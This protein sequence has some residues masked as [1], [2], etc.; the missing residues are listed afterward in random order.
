MF[1]LTKRS[2]AGVTVLTG[3]VL[4]SLSW[5]F[6][7]SF[8]S[9]LHADYWENFTFKR[10]QNPNMQR[11]YTIEIAF[12]NAFH[13]NLDPL[14]TANFLLL[15]KSVRFKHPFTS[16]G[17]WPKRSDIFLK[18]FFLPIFSDNYNFILC[19]SLPKI[20]V[21]ARYL[22]NYCILLS[23][24]LLIT[25]YLFP[26]DLRSPK[27]LLN[28]TVV[29]DQ[30]TFVC[31]HSKPPMLCQQCLLPL[32]LWYILCDDVAGMWVLTFWHPC[33]SV[34]T[35]WHLCHSVVHVQIAWGEQ[36]SSGF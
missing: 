10:P 21:W 17:I 34:L 9:L 18:V 3:I 30:Y 32:C 5:R 14:K 24:I 27:H 7:C 15:S 23:V 33:H 20:C 11:W 28:N 6:I 4:L 16:W 12:S 19:F 31:F 1:G 36:K 22:A 25:T 35:F 2:E 26:M 13:P 29:E 8:L